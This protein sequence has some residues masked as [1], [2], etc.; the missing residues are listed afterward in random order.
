MATFKKRFTIKGQGDWIDRI[1][2][3]ERERCGTAIYELSKIILMME[4]KTKQKFSLRVIRCGIHTAKCEIEC[5]DQKGY[6][7][8]KLA[9]LCKCGAYFDWRG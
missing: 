1:S 3:P 6:D 9:F 5:P 2:T 8:L 7:T 4:E